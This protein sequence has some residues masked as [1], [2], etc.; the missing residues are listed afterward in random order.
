MVSAKFRYGKGGSAKPYI[1]GDKAFGNGMLSNEFIR[2]SGYTGSLGAIQTQFKTSWDTHNFYL[3]MTKLGENAEEI[4]KDVLRNAIGDAIRE[5]KEH[6]RKMAGNLAQQRFPTKNIYV[7]IA[8]ALSAD[9]LEGRPDIRVH[10]GANERDAHFGVMGSRGGYLS[11]IVADGYS[12]YPY[13]RNLPPY[14]KSSLLWF[15]K[16][17]YLEDNGW[18]LRRAR[19]HPQ[20]QG[21]DYMEWIMD[22]TIEYFEKDMDSAIVYY[23][24]QLG[25]DAKSAARS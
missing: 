6:L 3:A 5:V 25:F 17:G 4:I 21:F 15:N 10:T 14:V 24:E 22:A 19:Y 13:S 2:K 1:L 16:T 23:A 8:D 7:K 20:F 18:F 9:E 12:S 11:K